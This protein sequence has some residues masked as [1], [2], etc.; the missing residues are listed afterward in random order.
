MRSFRRVGQQGPLTRLM[1]CTKEELAA[2]TPLDVVDTYIAPSFALDSENGDSYQPYN[3]P[4]AVTHW[5]RVRVLPCNL[6]MSTPAHQSLTCHMQH[7]IS[8]AHII[9]RA[10]ACY[11]LRLWT[12][13]H[14]SAARRLLLSLC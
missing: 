8:S 3:K 2:Y 14:L 10:C 6:S 5:L 13:V 4:G 7:C 12:T 9:T 11:H 1:P